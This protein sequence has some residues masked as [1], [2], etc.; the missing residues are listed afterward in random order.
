MLIGIDAHTVGDKLTGNETYIYYLIKS[1]SNLDSNNSYH[2]YY[3]KAKAKN[4]VAKDNFKFQKIKIH[5]RFVRLSMSFPFELYKHPVDILLVQ[6]IAPLIC[7]CRLIVTIHDIGYKR[8]PAFFTKAFRR[9]QSFLVPLN[10]KKARKIITISEFSKR[11]LIELYNVPEDKVSVT[12]LGVGEEFKPIK[13]AEKIAEITSRYK[14]NTKFILYTGNLQPRKNLV[15]L[16]G[17][18]NLLK[19]HKKIEHKLV[20]VGRKAWLYGDIFK[21]MESSEF[22]EDIIWTDYIPQN[23]LIMLY[24]VADVCVYLSLYEGFGL[25][26]VEAMACGTPVIAANS[27]SLPEVVGDAGIL[28]DPL[29]VESISKAICEVISNDKLR[30]EMV[31]KGLKRAKLFP[32]ENTAKKTLKILHEVC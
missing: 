29:D 24:N 16:I 5:N 2:I 6:Y 21:A 25:P 17:A 8:Y 15:R 9:R 4:F 3:T 14:I 26:L 30:Y 27:N 12:Y 28:V 10:I 7:P 19:K 32:W 23:D 1:L 20:I 31:E 22:A 13:D 11:E 18:F